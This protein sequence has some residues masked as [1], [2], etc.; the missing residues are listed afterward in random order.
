MGVV[1]T[2]LNT[3]TCNGPGCDKVITYAQA[4]EK[5]TFELPENV[6]LMGLRTIQTLDQRKFSYCSDTCELKGVESGQ[7][8]K[9]EPKKIISN[10]A[11]PAQIQQAA[12]AAKAAEAATIAIK[13]GQPVTLS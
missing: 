1:Q 6:W 4:K 10:V 13:A 7:H 2:V 11:T 3:I 12:D 8:N 5:E 9:P